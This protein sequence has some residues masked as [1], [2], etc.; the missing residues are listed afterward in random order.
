MSPDDFTKI[1]DF[2]KKQGKGHLAH[3]AFP[4]FIDNVGDGLKRASQA[5]SVSASQ[6]RIICENYLTDSQMRTYLTVAE[7]SYETDQQQSSRR[8]LPFWSSV[9]SSIVANFI[10]AG[11]VFALWLSLNGPTLNDV[12]KLWYDRLQSADSRSD[13]LP[14]PS[15]EKQPGQH[16]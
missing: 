13:K 14:A 4:M 11:L 8:T 6:K 16:R 7:K 12:F 15:E 2:F 10:F 5:G 1:N 3:L 9:W